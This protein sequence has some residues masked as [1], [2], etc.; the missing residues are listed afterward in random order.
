MNLL[1]KNTFS[2]AKMAE[3]ENNYVDTIDY[4]NDILNKFS[5]KKIIIVIM[6]I[7]KAK[8]VCQIMNLMLHFI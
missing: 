5:T 7:L 6:I 2:L 4:L 1:K 8:T 3:L